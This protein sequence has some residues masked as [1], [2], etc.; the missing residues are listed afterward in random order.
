MWLVP[1]TSLLRL[2]L[3][4]RAAYG[5]IGLP[6]RSI[7]RSASGAIVLGAVVDIAVGNAVPAGGL[8][9]QLMPL[10]AGDL[11]CWACSADSFSETG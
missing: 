9:A 4:L 10:L 7:G 1:A 8:V 3:L 6:L 5:R 11:E 2:M